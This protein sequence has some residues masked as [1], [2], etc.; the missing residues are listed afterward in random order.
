MDEATAQR[1]IEEQQRYYS[2]RAPEYDDWWLRRGRYDFG[3]EANAR[4]FADAAEAEGLLDT[5]GPRGDVLEL[6]AGT[7]LWTRHLVRYADTLTAVDA[8]P[9]TLEINRARVDAEVEYVVADLFTWEPPRRYDVCFFGFWLSHVPP[10]RFAEFWQLVDRALEPDGRFF[11][12]DS[13][14]PTPGTPSVQVDEHRSRRTLAD[15]REFEVVKR[16]YE[17]G[18]LERDLANL[19]WRA[20]VG[21]TPSGITLVGSGT[22][23]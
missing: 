1:L 9:E 7:G 10:T 4:W 18:T 13:A 19:G 23:A 12:V 3:P 17:P 16:W 21:T 6:A 11:F 5:F 8:A 14:D 15:G 22:R 2:A 20:S